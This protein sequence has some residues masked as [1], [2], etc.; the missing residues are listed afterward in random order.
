MPEATP[1]KIIDTHN[2]VSP[3]LLPKKIIDTHD[4]VSPDLQTANPRAGF[5]ILEALVAMAV[6]SVLLLGAMTTQLTLWQNVR[7][8]RE[9]V[10]AYALLHQAVEETRAVGFDQ[11]LALN[12]NAATVGTMQ[13]SYAAASEAANLVRLTVTV[14]PED[15]AVATAT[16][17]LL[18]SRW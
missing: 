12:G 8:A 16:V 1:K 7:A 4:W 3:D 2:W 11:L 15:P 6:V 5:M 17:T 13:V 9:G 10:S 14:T 18:R